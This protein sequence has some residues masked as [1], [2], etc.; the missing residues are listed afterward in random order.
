MVTVR[1]K[2]WADIALSRKHFRDPYGLCVPS[3]ITRSS[4]PVLLL[5]YQTILRCTSPMR[6]LLFPT[7]ADPKNARRRA[8]T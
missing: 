5:E 4:I 3:T 2:G 1:Q 7:H 6:V 8:T